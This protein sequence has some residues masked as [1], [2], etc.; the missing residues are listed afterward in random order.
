M[1]IFSVIIVDGNILSVK[2]IRIIMMVH[3]DGQEEGDAQG[4]NNNVRNIVCIN[5]IRYDIAKL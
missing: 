1:E 3:G 4:D 2:M 5:K